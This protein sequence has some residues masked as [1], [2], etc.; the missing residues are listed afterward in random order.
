MTP[1][2]DQ[3]VRLDVFVELFEK[4]ADVGLSCIVIG[5]CA[6]GVYAR[7]VGETVFSQDL[8]LFMSEPG[9]EALL[10]AS[11]LLGVEIQKR[12]QARSF[13]VAVLRWRG[14]EINVLTSTPGMPPADVAMRSAREM[15]LGRG[16]TVLI[17]D[18]C[19]LLRNKLSVNREKDAPHIDILRRFLDEEAIFGFTHETEARARIAPAE[20]LLAVLGTRTLDEALGRRLV[21]LARAPSDF[22]FLAH[23]LPTRALVADLLARA[24]TDDLRTLIESLSTRRDLG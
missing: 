5:G 4:I 18:P 19:D 9:L 7:R 20:R 15:A 22:R 21:A 6:V 23:R 14:L 24:Q 16:P 17:A 10:E 8:D 3:T 12:P 13:P 2:V 1:S 11:G